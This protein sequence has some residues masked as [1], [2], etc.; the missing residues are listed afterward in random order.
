MTDR[1]LSVQQVADML[2]CSPETVR[3]RTPHDLPGAKFG[4]RGLVCVTAL[5]GVHYLYI[6][7]T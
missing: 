4:V 2:G 5:Q 6:S 1:I 7:T 3:E